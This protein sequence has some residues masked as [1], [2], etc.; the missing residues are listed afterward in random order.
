MKKRILN[1]L[2]IF[3]LGGIAGILGVQIFLPWLAGFSFFQKFDW[4]AQSRSGTTVIN[5][6]ERVVVTENHALEEAIDGASKIM[7]GV[8]SERTEKIV[9]NKKIPL[10]RPEI[11]AQGS[12]FIVSSDG[13][14]VA[15]T[16]LVPTAAQKVF[17][18]LAG[19]ELRAEIKKTDKVSGLALLKINEN[20]LSVLPFVESDLKLG[21][22]VFL[23]GMAEQNYLFADLGVIKQVSPAPTAV[24]FSDNI[25]DNPI[26]N[27]KAEIVGLNFVDSGGKNKIIGVSTIKELLKQ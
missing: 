27:I 23:L 22:R 17:V 20:N 9:G 7:V 21:E 11:L 13:M 5:R 24:F 1:L 2:A 18:V 16:N 4:I 8:I 3:L 25:G 6:T 12:G 15:S 19:K 26:F 10:A 14:I